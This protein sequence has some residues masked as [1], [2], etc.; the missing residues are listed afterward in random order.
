M[1]TATHVGHNQW[2]VPKTL[3][4][5]IITSVCRTQK[6]REATLIRSFELT[7]KFKIKE[8]K[9]TYMVLTSLWLFLRLTIKFKFK[10]MEP[11]ILPT[12]DNCQTSSTKFKGF[13]LIRKFKKWLLKT[14]CHILNPWTN[15]WTMKENQIWDKVEKPPAD[16][17]IKA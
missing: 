17:T 11:S 5:W 16:K 12:V 14:K 10:N 7:R 4:F 6:L 9:N 2:M 15:Q 1:Q 3:A 8:K 13:K